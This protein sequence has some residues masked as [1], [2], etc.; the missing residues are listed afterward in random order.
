MPIDTAYLKTACYFRNLPPDSL[1]EIS[2]YV[3]EKRFPAGETILWEGRKDDALYFA[4]SGLVK[5]YA[6]SPDG[7]E[8]VVRL[9]YGGDSTNDEAIFSGEPNLLSARS[10]SQVLLYGLLKE[11][12]EKLR[13][14]YPL[15]NESIEKVFADHE[16]YLVRLSTELVF[17]NVTGRLARL[18]LEG[19]QLRTNGGKGLRMTQQEMASMI[20]TVREIVSRSLREMELMNAITL[21][22]NQIT[23]T[24]RQVLQQLVGV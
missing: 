6:T 12:L 5:L 18:I 11:D 21:G 17:K 1:A 3:F 9:A 20:G 16:R 7:R 8:F 15:L 19:E 24:N 13:R 4:I 23:I 22:H 2:K 14:A 10:M